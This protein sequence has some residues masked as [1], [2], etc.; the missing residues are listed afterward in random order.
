[1]D[2]LF[3]FCHST[4]QWQP[5]ETPDG[6][7]WRTEVYW[8][9]QSGS[10]SSPQADVSVC[11]FIQLLSVYLSRNVNSEAE[12][13]WVEMNSPVPQ[14]THYIVFNALAIQPKYMHIH[15]P[16]HEFVYPARS[17]PAF[18]PHSLAHLM[19]EKWKEIKAISFILPTVGCGSHEAEGATLAV[20]YC[21]AV[22]VWEVYGAQNAAKNNR[23]NCCSKTPTTGREK[24]RWSN[25][26]L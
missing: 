7:S 2:Y 20:K 12:Q 22:R 9:S 14:H 13:R 25:T 17:R 11:D 26:G 16:W 8:E 15:T 3:K 19:C 24:G 23:G 10:V 21:W 4:L 6:L 5:K 1:M 18:G